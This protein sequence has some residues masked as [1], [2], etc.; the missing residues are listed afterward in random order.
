MSEDNLYLT[1]SKTADNTFHAKG[2][3]GYFFIIE[4]GTTKRH[5]Q[6][7]SL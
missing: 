4:K 3:D 2:W 7:N 5:S 6:K 1:I